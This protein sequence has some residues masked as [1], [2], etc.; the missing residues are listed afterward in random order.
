MKGII[1]AGGTG[2]RMS[3]L[4]DVTSKHLLPIGKK[5]M[6]FYPVEKLV[7]AGIKEIMIITGTEHAGNV[8]NLLG[9]GSRFGCNFTYRIQDKAGGIAQALSLCESFANAEPIC[10]LLGDNIFS[11][12]I[13]KDKEEFEKQFP[14][15]TPC[16]KIMLYEVERPERFG[17]AKIEGEKIVN[18]VEKPKEFISNKIVTGIYFYDN[19]VFDFI[20]ELK[21]SDRG[22][23]EITDV[24][25][26]Y[27]EEN[28]LEY[29]TFNGWWTDAGTFESF[30]YANMMVK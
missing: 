18:I 2:S 27:I 22:E 24:N 25:N 14:Q 10:V 26:R 8:F 30:K 3:P 28:G 9:S 1:L 21:P 5:P 6:I 29:G 4:T 20:R 11:D 15:S 7:E 17:V 13:K 12:S 16:A 23:Y 19:N